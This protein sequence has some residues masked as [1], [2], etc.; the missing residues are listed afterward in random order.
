MLNVKQAKIFAITLLPARTLS[1]LQNAMNKYISVNTA[2][3]HQ[4]RWKPITLFKHVVV[5]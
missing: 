2:I 5:S 3:L 4:R 1:M